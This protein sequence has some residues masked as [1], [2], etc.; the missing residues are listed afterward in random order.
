MPS[1]QNHLVAALCCVAVMLAGTGGIARSQTAPNGRAMTPDDLLTRQTLG[2]TA[3][4]PDGKWVA[5]VVERPRKAGESYER[6]YLRGL[7]RSDIWLA[8]TDGKML[9]NVT[10][11]EAVHGGHWNPLWSP[12]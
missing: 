1:K 11:G 9:L 2:E 10:H 5:I 7:E 3:L 12:D 6:G 8:S 4:S